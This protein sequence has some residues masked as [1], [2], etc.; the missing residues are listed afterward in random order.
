S[1]K[2]TATPAWSQRARASRRSFSARRRGGQPAVQGRWSLTVSVFGR[3]EGPVARRR[4]LAELLL[5]R[6]GIVTREQVLAE[7]IPGGFSS[8]YDSLAARGAIG[9]ARRGYF[10]QGVG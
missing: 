9:I 7:G 1:P 5:E 3:D 6:Y 2:L 8:L 10:V 4:P